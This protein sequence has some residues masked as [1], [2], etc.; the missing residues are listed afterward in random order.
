[1]VNIL[2]RQIKLE[3]N[4]IPLCRA[5]VAAKFISGI[6]L[7]IQVHHQGQ[8]VNLNVIFFKFVFLTN[9]NSNK[10]IILRFHV[11]LLDNPAMV[12]F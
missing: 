8:K 9:T 4:G 5:I 6:I 3:T 2:F 10:C 1:M 7:L 11:F 12:L